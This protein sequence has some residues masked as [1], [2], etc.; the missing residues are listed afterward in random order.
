MN[1]PREAQGEWHSVR[2]DDANDETNVVWMPWRE[3]QAAAPV[4]RVVDRRAGRI[5]AATL[6]A[7]DAYPLEV[8]V[9]RES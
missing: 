9:P 1:R 7:C 2:D 8:P 6:N 3:D 5:L 4:I